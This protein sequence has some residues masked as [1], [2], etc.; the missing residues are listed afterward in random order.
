MNFVKRIIQKELPFLLACPALIWQFFFLYLPLMVLIFFSFTKIEKI[1]ELLRF[2]FSHYQSILNSLYLKVI[3]H[4]AILATTTASICLIIAYPVAY[5]FAMKIKRFK[6][7]LLFSLI[8]PS[9]TSFIVQVYAWFFLLQKQ[10][11]LS[12]VLQKLG[13]ISDTTHLLN[14]YFSIL[15]G[16]V[17]CFLPF[18]ILPIYAVLERMDKSL[19]Q[20][21]ADLGANKLQTFKRIIFP[22]SFPGV[23]AGFLLVFIPSFGE[24]AVPDLLGGGQKAVFWGTVIVEK[25]LMTKD[26]QSGSALTVV[27][28]LFLFIVF[29]TIYMITRLYKKIMK[30][31]TAF[32]PL[33]SAKFFEAN[34]TSD[35][36]E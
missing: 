23:M 25:F 27:G 3:L 15:I 21:S 34:T 26:W 19:L 29:L 10:G 33:Y 16:M 22:I 18:M 17:Y 8:L 2:T 4:S 14:N 1:T 11:F 12:F 5:F 6:T 36:V 13:I 32:K 7:L 9:W 20:A 30:R 24:F 31:S 28:V 35:E